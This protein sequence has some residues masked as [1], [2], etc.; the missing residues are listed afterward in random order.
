MTP[1]CSKRNLM[2]FKTRFA[3]LKAATQTLFST[4]RR[5]LPV[6]VAVSLKCFKEHF[7]CSIWRLS[8]SLKMQ[9]TKQ[10]SATNTVLRASMKQHISRIS[11]LLLAMKPSLCPFTAWSTVVSSKSSTMMPRSSL[12][13]SSRLA[14]RK[15]KA[16][17]MPSSRPSLS[18]ASEVTKLRLSA[19]L[20]PP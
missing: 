8:F 15:A 17:N 20:I 1:K 13:S 10:R 3:L 14:S 4:F 19:S 7:N 5:Y 16:L 18:G 12:N 6:S 2:S 11:E 9:V